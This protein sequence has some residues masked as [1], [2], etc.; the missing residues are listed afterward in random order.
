MMT[1]RT[2][3]T[4]CV[5]MVSAIAMA[6]HL[7]GHRDYSY[8]SRE[9]K[10]I[11]K[12]YPDDFFKTPE[13]RR[14]AENVLIYQRNTGGWPKNLPIHRELG[15]EKEIVLA[16]KSKRNDSTTDNDATITE[17]TYLARL[18]H[19]LSAEGKA[20]DKAEE[21]AEDKADEGQADQEKADAEQ[22]EETVKPEE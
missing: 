7:T 15:Q 18:Y 5:V 20:E 17:M 22:K 2:L 9:W 8:T 13:A 1:K 11:A 19:I 10:Q 16:D 3:I 6:Q 4:F 12:S 21:T 14:I